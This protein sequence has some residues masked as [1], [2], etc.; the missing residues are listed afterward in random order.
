MGGS[1]SA[2]RERGS[3][4]MNADASTASPCAYACSAKPGDEVN[5]LNAMEPPN[6]KPAPDQPFPLSTQRVKSTIPKATSDKGETWEYPSPQMFWNAMLKKGWR[7]KEDAIGQKDMENIIE[8]HNA[9]NEKAWK[10]VLLWENILHPECDCPKLKSF[11]G[12]AKNISPKARL[13]HW[14]GYELPFDRHDWIVDRC[15]KREVRYIIDYY[16][17]GPVDSKTKLFTHLDVRPALTDAENAWDRLLVWYWRFKVD[18]LGLNPKLPIPP[19]EDK[20]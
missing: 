8:I 19:F 10:E 17:A 9:N 4:P 3:C 1:E 15:G 7:W 14:L 11:K 6:Q 12:D 13:R 20:H 16:D 2:P 18:W 5:P